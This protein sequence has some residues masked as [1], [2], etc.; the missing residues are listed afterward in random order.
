MRFMMFVK[1]TQTLETRAMPSQEFIEAKYNQELIA[2]DIMH[3][4]GG[5]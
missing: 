3:G 1:A 4:G 5:L 2:T